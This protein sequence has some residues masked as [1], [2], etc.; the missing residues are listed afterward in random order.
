MKFKSFLR[1]FGVRSGDGLGKR[2]RRKTVR[3]SARARSIRLGVEALE[4][5]TL[6]SV[7][8][9]P[10]VDPTAA[11]HIDISGVGGNHSS[12]SVAID[13][14]NPQHL[15]AVWTRN[16]P[17]LGNVPIVTE[18]AVSTTGGLSWR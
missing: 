4:D 10:I 18:G 2:S 6:M 11:T 3:P 9:T 17:S 12:P 16:D 14:V 13:P 1:F 7:L 15:A 5:R 8:P